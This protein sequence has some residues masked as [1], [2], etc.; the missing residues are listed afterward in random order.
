MRD[1]VIAGKKQFQ[2]RKNQICTNKLLYAGS[3]MHKETF[4]RRVKY[5]QRFTYTRRHFLTKGQFSTRIK[6]SILT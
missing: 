4:V 5:A 6:K 1:D 3:N 2:L